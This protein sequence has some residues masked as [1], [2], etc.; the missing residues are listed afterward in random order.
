M[1]IGILTFFS[2]RN[3]GAALQAYALQH[4]VKSFGYDCEFIN[5]RDHFPNQN[6]PM[7]KKSKIFVYARLGI[8]ILSQMSTYMKTRAALHK[9]ENLFSDFRKAYMNIASQTLYDEEDLIN[10]GKAYDAFI[11][12]S[13]MVWT[14]IGQDLDYYFM[15]LN[16]ESQEV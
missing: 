15:R 3:Y 12:G 10:A 14:P 4:V 16:V 7:S 2:T 11:A 6:T 5:Y 9:A 1:K 8:T 13:D